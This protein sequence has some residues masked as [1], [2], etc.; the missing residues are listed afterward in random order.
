MG[1]QSAL[2]LDADAISPYRI[3]FFEVQVAGQD[4]KGNPVILRAKMVAI[5]EKEAGNYQFISTDCLH[6]FTPLELGIGNRELGI[7]GNSSL[8]PNSKL[9]TPNSCQPPTPEEQQ[10]LEKWL[11]VKTQMKLMQ[12]E[13]EKRERELHIRQDYLTKAMEAAISDAKQAYIT[14]SGKVAKGDDTYRVA[15]DNAQNKVRTLTERYQNKQNE[16]NYLQLVRPGRLVYLGTA[17]V[18]PPTEPISSGMRNDPEVE[19]I[20]MEFVMNYERERGWTP[21]DISQRNDGSGFDIRSEGQTDEIT[22]NLPIRRIEVKGRAGM[23]QDVSLTSN[24]WRRAQQLGDTYWLY[25]VWNCQGEQPQLL[26]IQN[27]ALVLAGEVKEIKQVTRYIVGAEALAKIEA[28][29]SAAR[30]KAI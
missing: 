11:K 5:R 4:I 27:P 21:E 12:E 10:A 22:G 14:L 29:E 23:N 24:E 1:Y 7:G 19:A 17:L 20:A 25:V 18:I 6:D 28:R 13:R 9:L 2:F 8:N 26:T 3:H 15:R 16:L 30:H